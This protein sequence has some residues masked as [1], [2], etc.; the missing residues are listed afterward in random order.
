MATA[1]ALA[2]IS[3]KIIF[4]FAFVAPCG[5]LQT[6]FHGRGR[7]GD[8]GICCTRS[9]AGSCRAAT[10]GLLNRRSEK[11]VQQRRP[12]PAA[13]AGRSCWGSGL[14]DASAAQGTKQTQGA[15]TRLSEAA[16]IFS[17]RPLPWDYQRRA[18]PCL[19]RRRPPPVADTG[20]SCWGS[21]LQDASAAQGT[22]QTQGAATRRVQRIEIA[23]TLPR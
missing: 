23:A 14:Q 4:I 2:I 21:G 19:Q 8:S 16:S 11:N 9:P 20:R 15:A 18:A 10:E 5:A 7:D 1:C 17:F 13:D 6:H 3:G 22:K 12:P